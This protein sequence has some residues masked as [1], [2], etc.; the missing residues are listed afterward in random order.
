MSKKN[1]QGEICKIVSSGCTS[2]KSYSSERKAANSA[3][4]DWTFVWPRSVRLMLLISH[5]WKI[6]SVH[7][8]LLWTS[9]MVLSIAAF[10]K[11]PSRGRERI[12]LRNMIKKASVRWPSLSKALTL[13]LQ[14]QGPPLKQLTSIT[15]ALCSPVKSINGNPSDWLQLI[16][17]VT[18]DANGHWGRSGNAP[19]SQLC[20]SELDDRAGHGY[21]TRKEWDVWFCFYRAQKHSPVRENSVIQI[22]FLWL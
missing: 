4:I 10:V 2:F 14:G 22:E 5:Q 12:T 13:Q 11:T 8:C 18:L 16:N 17:M 3:G 19:R 7:N 20:A 15:H 9:L 21:R 1:I 6:A